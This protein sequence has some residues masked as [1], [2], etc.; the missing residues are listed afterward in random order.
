MSGFA[1]CHFLCKRL[2]YKLHIVIPI[3]SITLQIMKSKR[4]HVV[5]HLD[6]FLAPVLETKAIQCHLLVLI[7]IFFFFF[8]FCCVYAISLL[9]DL[10]SFFSPFIKKSATFELR[11]HNRCLQ[12]MWCM[13]FANNSE[14]YQYIS[15][16]KTLLSGVH[17]CNLFSIQS[18]VWQLQ[19]VV[20]F[21]HKVRS[22][23]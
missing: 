21:D 5:C 7:I 13:S 1:N 18:N 9:I 2:S 19:S 20:H 11:E 23:S 3:T 15:I 16:P 17:V 8:F 4:H 22:A 10:Q 14:H 12:I 6:Q